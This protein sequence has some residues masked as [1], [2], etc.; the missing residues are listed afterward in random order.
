M[1]LA[2]TGSR[3][4]LGV[5]LAQELT[6]RY[7]H[8]RI[9]LIHRTKAP[10]FVACDLL[11]EEVLRRTLA[12]L[13]P[14]VVFHLA[15]TTRDGGWEGLW[16]AHV[17]T[18]VN[19]ME[20]ILRLP[21]PQRVKIVIAASSAEYGQGADTRP[22]AET[23]PTRPVT[24]YGSAKLSQTLAALSYQHRGLDVVVARIF[25]AVGPGIP[26][27][28]ALGTF[29]DQI[30]QI[31]RGLK[32]PV[33]KVGNLKSRR[34]FVDARD[35][36]RALAEL[37]R[38]GKSGEIYN[39]CSGRSVSVGELLRGLIRLSGLKVSVKQRE[40]HRG[41]DLPRITGSR[42]K[43][44]AATGWRPKIPLERSLGDTLSWYRSR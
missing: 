27:R 40:R 12:R 36:A 14:S 4:F 2:I 32:P 11:D 44:A 8:A 41:S 38:K 35:A 43:I 21:R 23:S 26:V 10:G 15:G 37:A 28:L 1:N 31:E 22:V 5:H 39:V 30:V 25:N 9:S 16:D 3:G 6:A 29:A 18:T 33:L 7:P 42:R 19:L 34:D 13:K 24:V 20:A 17:R